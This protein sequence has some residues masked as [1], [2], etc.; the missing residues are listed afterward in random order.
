MLML[1]MMIADDADYDYDY[2]AHDDNDDDN[3]YGRLFSPATNPSSWLL[4]PLKKENATQK[5]P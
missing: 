3:N 2:A 5:A 1:M 4:G